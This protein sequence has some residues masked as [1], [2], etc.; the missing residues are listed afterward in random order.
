MLKL[1]TVYDTIV[2]INTHEAV[3]VEEGNFKEQ[4]AW[5]IHLIT[6][7]T[8]IVYQRDYPE[9]MLIE[10][11]SGNYGFF[12]DEYNKIHSK[13]KEEINKEE[14]EIP[15]IPNKISRWDFHYVNNMEEDYD[16]PYYAVDDSYPCYFMDSDPL[17]ATG[18]RIS[19]DLAMTLCKNY[20]YEDN[21]RNISWINVN[22]QLALLFNRR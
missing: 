11:L 3:Y 8:I 20:S 5:Y 22:N 19:E 21:I 15:I 14:K 9:D 2:F 13:E 17:K 4:L 16:D 10:G 12:W 18:I 7:D 1:I 6:N